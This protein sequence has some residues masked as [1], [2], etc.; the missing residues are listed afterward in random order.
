MI[1]AVGADPGRAGDGAAAA[2]T[3]G[4]GRPPADAGDL[5]ATLL[6]RS[7]FLT[8]PVFT[9]HRSE[10]AMLR[11]LRRLAD[12]RHRA[13]PVHDPARLLHDEAQ[14]DRRDGADQLAGFA[15]LHPFAPPTRPRAT[16]R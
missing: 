12:L 11:Y 1:E 4:D 16:R 3:A 6:R 8:H 10:T 5:P 2:S 13:G 14:R 15:G 9:S 7:A